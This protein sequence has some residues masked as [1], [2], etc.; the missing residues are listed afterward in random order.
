MPQIVRPRIAR[1]GKRSSNSKLERSFRRPRQT[2]HRS[3]SRAPAADRTMEFN[4]HVQKWKIET[5]HTSP[6]KVMIA[7]PSYR[8]I[9][10]MGK[11]GLPLLF[12]ELERQPDHWFV[13]LSAMTGIDPVP[14]GATFIE[15]VSAWLEWGRAEGYLPTWNDTPILKKIFRDYATATTFPP[16]AP[17]LPTTA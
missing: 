10:G 13:A 4:A 2:V 3:R 7:H 14:A 9:M 6:V 8:R 11:E 16:V 5:R 17:T 1:H 12:R 15:G